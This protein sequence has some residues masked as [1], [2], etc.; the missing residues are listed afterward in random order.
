MLLGRTDT[1]IS[2]QLN[3]ARKTLYN[4]RTNNP[5]FRATFDTR[6]ELL[7]GDATARLVAS[8]EQALDTLS[9]QAHHPRPDISHRAARSILAL[10]RI[11]YHL[12][13][14]CKRT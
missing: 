4:W 5:L 9:A 1:A 12:V 10:S 7:L 8:I 3:I 6:R 13:P 14:H 11:G 2:Q